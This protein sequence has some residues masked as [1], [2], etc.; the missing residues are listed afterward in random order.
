[1]EGIIGMRVSIHKKYTVVVSIALLAT[2][3]AFMAIVRWAVVGYYE[4]K[5][6]ANG[7]FFLH[8]IYFVYL[9]HY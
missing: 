3:V 4:E 5:V 9:N 1:M 6:R 8:I 7:S 2:V